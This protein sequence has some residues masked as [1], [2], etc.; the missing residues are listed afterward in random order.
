MAEA[1]KLMQTCLHLKGNKMETTRDLK[2]NLVTHHMRDIKRQIEKYKNGKTKNVLYVILLFCDAFVVFVLICRSLLAVNCS[3][4]TPC[5]SN[6]PKSLPGRT[7]DGAFTNKFMKANRRGHICVN[8]QYFSSD[9][10]G[11]TCHFYSLCVGSRRPA[12]P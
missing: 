10:L 3:Q 5:S 4:M 11:N 9:K 8:T 12:A 1:F 7:G 2:L 6:E